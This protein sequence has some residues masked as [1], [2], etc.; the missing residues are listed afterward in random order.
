MGKAVSKSHLASFAK[1]AKDF[2]DGLHHKLRRK[3]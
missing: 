3:Q 2:Y 1:V